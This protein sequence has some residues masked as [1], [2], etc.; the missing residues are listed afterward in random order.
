[1]IDITVHGCIFTAIRDSIRRHAPREDMSFAYAQ[2]IEL[3]GMVRYVV[4]AAV[5]LDDDEAERSC[6]A[7][8]PSLLVNKAIYG[9]H[10]SEHFAEQGVVVIT[11]HSHPFSESVHFSGID[12]ATMKADRLE[13]QKLTPGIEFLWVVFDQ[14]GTA[15]DGLVVT[16]TK[17]VP[18]SR[19]TV[20]DSKL[21]IIT[22]METHH[23]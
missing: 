2:R 14:K 19:I 1:M 12:L 10:V 21:E 17:F 16:P 22:A 7:V 11:I 23:A 20:L 8:R 9:T 3:P 5:I 4:I 18:I 13:W 15:F 6:Y